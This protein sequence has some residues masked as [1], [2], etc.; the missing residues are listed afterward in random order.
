[1]GSNKHYLDSYLLKRYSEEVQVEIFSS[2]S[3][4]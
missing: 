3:G 1:M 2:G 4:R